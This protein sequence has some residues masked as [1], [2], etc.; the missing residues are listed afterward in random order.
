MRTAMSMRMSLS[1]AVAV[2]LVIAA[3]ARA[4]DDSGVPPPDA[5]AISVDEF[6]PVEVTAGGPAEAAQA[7][8]GPGGGYAVAPGFAPQWNVQGGGVYYSPTLRGHFRA[9]WLLLRQ[10]G[11]QFR[12]WGARIVH[13]DFN[14]PLR[15]IGLSPGD[16]VTRLD[17]ISVA[18][19]MFRQGNQPWQMVQMEQH[20]GRTE[21]RYIIRGTNVVQCGDMMLDGMYPPQFLDEHMLEP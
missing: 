4:Q 20:F 11:R 16:V 21:V 19:G 13:L 3:V 8:Q 2:T 12:F 10:G 1:A 5:E 17:G 6:A 9:Q 18:R 15:Q 7:G 14:S